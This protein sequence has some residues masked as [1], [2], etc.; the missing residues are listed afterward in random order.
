VDRRVIALA[1]ELDDAQR[2]TLATIAERTP[3]TR[4]VRTGTEI[5][6]TFDPA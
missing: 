3:V 4:A 1:G 6:T 5:R 2:A